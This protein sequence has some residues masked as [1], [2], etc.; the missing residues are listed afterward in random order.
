MLRSKFK[1]C[2]VAAVLCFLVSLES[3]LSV[4]ADSR[5]F[6]QN[7]GV[8]DSYTYSKKSGG[9][10]VVDCPDVFLPVYT[11]NGE[12]LGT[13][14][15]NPEHIFEKDGKIYIINTGC[16][17]VLICDEEFN[18]IKIIDSFKNGKKTDTFN[19]PQGGFVT[20]NG[21]IYIADTGNKR[22][23]VLNSD[24]GL[25]KIIEN[26][27]SDVFAE[28]FEFKPK[29]IVVDSAN[30]IFIIAEG[31]YEG[32]M[33]FYEDGSFVGFVGSIPVTANP[34]EIMWKKILS[35]DQTSKMAQFI[36]VSYTNIFLDHE[37]FLYAVS[38]STSIETPIRRLNPGG[39][40]VLARNALANTTVTGD[41]VGAQS[42]FVA[43]CA[44]ESGIYYAADSTKSR[45]FVY[46]DDG[47]MLCAFGGNYSGQIG[48]FQMIASLMFLDDQLIVVDS[49]TSTITAMK[50]TDYMKLLKEGINTYR[51]GKYDESDKVWRNLLTLNSNLDL[52][53]S[54][55]G[56]I[57][58]RRKN[59]EEAMKYFKLAN[60]QEN[61]SRAY[62]KYQT[63]WYTKNLPILI[64]AG[65]ILIAGIIGIKIWL[66][67][68]RRKEK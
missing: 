44:D 17:N 29:K 65:I 21:D 5:V 40:D 24:L 55:I 60:D 9:T 45:I 54:K 49:Q 1:I 16:S 64:T 22:V 61:Y 6:T 27:E 53:Y 34:L 8:S 59:Y 11:V 12:S 46:D 26:P 42:Q 36:P 10:M 13:N 52:A 4:F 51:S 37:G 38:L 18:V 41:Q 43:I 50:P 14:L 57:E 39:S 23:V 62:K 68:R 47:N 33:Q 58:I 32:I 67:R 56:M 28:D 66:K 35:D 25:K 20:E 48:T 3:L 15:V 63:I 19:A 7:S 30:R 2:I 31:I